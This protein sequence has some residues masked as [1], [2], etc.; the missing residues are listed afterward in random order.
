MTPPSIQV[1][2]TAEDPMRLEAELACCQVLQAKS[3]QD[4]GVLK[5]RSS[6]DV[7]VTKRQD[8]PVPSL[9]KSVK[10]GDDDIQLSEVAQ[11]PPEDIQ[12]PSMIRSEVEQSIGHQLIKAL[13]NFK[14][15]IVA[16]L[17]STNLHTSSRKQIV[18]VSTRSNQRHN[19]KSKFKIKTQKLVIKV[20]C[21][22]LTK[23][24]IFIRR[25]KLLDDC[26]LKPFHASRFEV[27]KKLYEMAMF[28][29]ALRKLSESIEKMKR[30]DSDPT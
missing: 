3:G 25:D 5:D 6:F 8:A 11:E 18:F 1:S 4:K 27:V 7:M 9:T 17:S 12:T 19:Q 24:W 29:E 23:K 16:P 10:L 13:S 20:T 30:K 28:M 26:A 14:Q 2:K 21:D 15:S 22:M